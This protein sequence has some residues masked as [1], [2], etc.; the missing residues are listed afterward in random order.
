MSNE[1][2][3]T[4]T[5]TPKGGQ[6]PTILIGGIEAFLEDRPI[7]PPA[8]GVTETNER[9]DTH[10]VIRMAKQ[11]TDPD[12]RY[13]VLDCDVTDDKEISE[14]AVVNAADGLVLFA[15][16]VLG[17]KYG[18]KSGA[19]TWQSTSKGLTEVLSPSRC[20]GVVIWDEARTLPH[21]D[22]MDRQVGAPNVVTVG[23]RVALASSLPT[24]LTLEAPISA[25]DFCRALAPG[26]FSENA[27]R[28]C[29]VDRCRMIQYF[30]H[31]LARL[32]S[33]MFHGVGPRSIGP[34]RASM[35]PAMPRMMPMEDDDGEC[36]ED[37]PVPSGPASPGSVLTRSTPPSGPP[38]R[39][40]PTARPPVKGHEPVLHVGP[41]DPM[42]VKILTDRIENLEREKILLDR[43]GSDYKAQLEAMQRIRDVEEASRLRWSQRPARILKEGAKAMAIAI[44]AGAAVW[45]VMATQVKQ[46]EESRRIAE[47][48]YG[49]TLYALRLLPQHER[50]IVILDSGGYASRDQVPLVIQR[51]AWFDGAGRP[52]KKAPVPWHDRHPMAD[53]IASTKVF[54]VLV[55]FVLLVVVIAINGSLLALTCLERRAERE[56]RQSRI[57]ATDQTVAAGNGDR[58]G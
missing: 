53:I 57:V 31:S 58:A 2:E 1:T 24:L 19:L 32:P 6:S 28:D 39:M 10:L 25:V 30:L 46:T 22:L 55:V 40:A 47:R 45:I 52:P 37:G 16:K 49:A 51:A 33:E 50:E 42:A 8:K 15:A 11:L 38:P 18:P 26:F 41:D 23:K 12:G 56:K 21:I 3:P 54:A 43:V 35:P 4:I 27:F 36:D 17:S 7:G 5:G 20:R 9:P 29:A 34:E 13:V 14:I 48:A 44:L